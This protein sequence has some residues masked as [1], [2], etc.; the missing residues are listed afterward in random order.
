M[1]F[2]ILTRIFSTFTVIRTICIARTGFFYVAFTVRVVSGIYRDML[3]SV[4]TVAT[5][6]GTRITIIAGNLDV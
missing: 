4:V 2:S 1:T 3:A 6:N 5:V